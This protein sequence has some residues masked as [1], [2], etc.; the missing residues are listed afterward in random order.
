VLEIGDLVEWSVLTIHP[1]DISGM[2]QRIREGRR[3]DNMIVGTL[4][5][6]EKH[7][8]M[9]SNIND[10]DITILHFTGREELH[11]LIEDAYDKL[12]ILNKK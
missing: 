10:F 11:M 9:I 5:T 4:T 2:H 7:T 8:G 1:N 6:Y 12:T 3:L